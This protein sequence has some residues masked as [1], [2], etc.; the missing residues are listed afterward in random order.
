MLL[1][2]EDVQR[3]GLAAGAS[4]KIAAGVQNAPLCGAPVLKLFVKRYPA[5]DPARQFVTFI[6]T[7]LERLR[8]RPFQP[9]ETLV[10]A[11][12]RDEL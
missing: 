10:A 7:I 2:K 12:Q 5:M 8:P 9:P 3:V 1:S 11:G 4:S 6:P